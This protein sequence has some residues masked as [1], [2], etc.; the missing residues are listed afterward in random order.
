MK[1]V[2][3]TLYIISIT[4]AAVGFPL[5]LVLIYL[6]LIDSGIPSKFF[7]TASVACCVLSIL[8]FSLARILVAWEEEDEKEE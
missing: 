2:K 3:V 5:A 6:D 1:K 4:L 8:S 7:W